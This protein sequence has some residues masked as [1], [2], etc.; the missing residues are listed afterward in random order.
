MDNVMNKN[1]FSTDT[2]C[3]ELYRSVFNSPDAQWVR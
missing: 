1:I 2:C 3:G